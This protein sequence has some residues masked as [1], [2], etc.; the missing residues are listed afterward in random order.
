MIWIVLAI[1]LLSFS[2]NFYLFRKVQRAPDVALENTELHRVIDQV[3][4]SGSALPDL[5]ISLTNLAASNLLSVDS[6]LKS[7]TELQGILNGSTSGFHKM[8]QLGQQNIVNIRSRIDELQ[9][10]IESIE[11]LNEHNRSVTETVS[12]LE[13]ISSQTSILALNASVEAARAG[14][15][16]KGFAVIAKSV[17]ELASKSLSA[18]ESIKELTSQS[19]KQGEEIAKGVSQSSGA[20]ENIFESINEIINSLK[21]GLDSFEENAQIVDTIVESANNLD[22]TVQQNLSAVRESSHIGIQLGVHLDDLYKESDYENEGSA[23][24]HEF[25]KPEHVFHFN[26]TNTLPALY[27]LYGVSGKNL[28]FPL[29]QDTLIKP[30]DVYNELLSTID[31][32]QKASSIS[33]IGIVRREGDVKP[34]D[35]LKLSVRFC[36]IIQKHSGAEML[37]KQLV[38]QYSNWKHGRKI[39][40]S[41]VLFLVN[42]FSSIIGRKKALT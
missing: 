3:G 25:I 7:T 5:S 32:F 20:L 16:G 17:R 33:D 40:P 31:R 1:L 26:F 42:Y 30:D 36:E 19:K 21:E 15:H 38:I 2:Y 35:V 34:M 22:H 9:G 27:K 23:L 10:F 39:M 28:S 4:K 6:F 14:S 24:K 12:L 29:S 11:E 8:D 41:D 37:D 13:D 18:S